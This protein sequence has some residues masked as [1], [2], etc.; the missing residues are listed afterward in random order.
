MKGT[1]SIS[2]QNNHV[3]YEFEIRRNITVIQGN[4]ASGKT[5]LVD[6]IREFQLNGS[7]SGINFSC[8]KKCYVLEGNNWKSELS[9][10]D[11]CIVFIDEGN[12]FIAST[13]FSSA[14][15]GSN[16]YYVII[17]REGLEN[18]PYSVNEIYGIHTSGKYAGLKQI[19]HEF[20]HI[21]SDEKFLSDIS[22]QKVLT[23][24]SN[25]GYEFFKLISGSRFNCE[26]ANGKSNVFKK[27]LTSNDNT[28]VI[29]DGAAFGSQMKKISELM[30]LKKNVVLFLPESFEYILLQA[31]LF[32]DSEISKI[33]NSPSEYIDGSKYFSWEQFFTSL[34]VSKSEKS[35]LKYSKKKLNLNYFSDN[36]KRKILESKA[37]S[38]IKRFFF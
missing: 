38:A 28:L 16:N 14:I 15:K 10:L 31:D 12:S 7:D 32:K 17:T 25:S 2:V 5:T 23:E 13:E 24:D 20:Y 18:L 35:F 11:D 1:Y 21:Y 37:F 26:S 22:I 34:L 8:K 3:K 30:M 19:Y 27:L 9:L 36:V 6:L 33:L 4:S 29:A